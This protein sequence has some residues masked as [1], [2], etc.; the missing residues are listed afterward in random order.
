MKIL[1]FFNLFLVTVQSAKVN[2]LKYRTPCD[3]HWTNQIT[4]K[5]SINNIS[6]DHT[7]LFCMIKFVGDLRQVGGFLLVLWFPPPIKLTAPRYN[8]NFVE[9][10]LNTV[11][12]TNQPKH[13]YTLPL[14]YLAWCR[15]F[16]KIVKVRLVS[17]P[18]SSKWNDANYMSKSYP[19]HIT[20]QW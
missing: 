4:V 14:A 18:L 11:N 19:L 5:L 12:Q 16:N 6:K 2:L 1:E 13:S 10:V 17:C 3:G 9:S 8:W 20:V 7:V 15:H